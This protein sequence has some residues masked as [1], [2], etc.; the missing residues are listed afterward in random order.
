MK[1]IRCIVCGNTDK[2]QFRIRF[3]KEDCTV[4]ECMRCTFHFIPPWYRKQIDYREY[5]TTEAA[6][7]VKSGNQWLKTEMNRRRLRMIRKNHKGRDLFD[8]G[9]GF[10][11]FM[12]AGKNMGYRVS[13]IEIARAN[14]EFIRS[15]LG[16]PVSEG[17]F[18]KLDQ[19]G[20]YDILTFWDTLEHMDHADQSVEKASCLLRPGGIIVIQV[21][22]LDSVLARLFKEKWWAMGLDHV[23]YF[24]RPTIRMLLEKYGFQVR[25]IKSSIELKI[26]Y[27][28]VIIPKLKKRRKAEKSWTFAERQQAFNRLT[29]KPRWMLWIGMR[30]YN[31]LYRTLSFL[32]IGDEMVVVAVKE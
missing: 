5:R 4:V 15:E 28:Y 2:N 1:D 10:G 31:A 3:E 12:L 32:R 14:A 26:I 8:V 21:P 9:A 6:S 22:Q 18:L 17:D 7:Q 20:R 16:L 30:I 11:H 23:N 24:T 27:N 25:V 19:S 13:G 29:Q